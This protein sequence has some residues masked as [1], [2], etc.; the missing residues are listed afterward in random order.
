MR[1]EEMDPLHGASGPD[2]KVERAADPP[3]SDWSASGLRATT[4][5]ADPN[6]SRQ[7]RTSSYPRRRNAA[8]NVATHFD[9]D[10]RRRRHPSNTFRHSG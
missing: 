5:A 6:V 7:T 8:R 9:S 2:G 1:V 10:T 4:I 3:P